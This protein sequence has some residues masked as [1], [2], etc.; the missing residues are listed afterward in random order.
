M[1]RCGLRRQLR[2]CVQK[3]LG[4]V[5]GWEHSREAASVLFCQIGPWPNEARQVG[6]LAG[7]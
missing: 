7:L 4:G 1:W 2:V 5:N 3:R 6:R